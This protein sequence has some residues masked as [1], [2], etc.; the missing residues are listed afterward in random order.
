MNITSFVIFFLFAKVAAYFVFNHK[1][2]KKTPPIEDS[3]KIKIPTMLLFKDSEEVIRYSGF[4][5]KDFLM[6]EI[7]K[8]Q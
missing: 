7:A 8:V 5:T 4:K 2:E 3:D 6:K 1:N